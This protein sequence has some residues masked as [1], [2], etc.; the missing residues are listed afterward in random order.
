MMSVVLTS[1]QCFAPV[2]ERFDSG[3]GPAAGPDASVVVT[4][5]GSV[6]AVL[7]G[8]VSSVDASMPDASS[9][10]DAGVQLEVCDGVDNDHDGLIDRLPDGGL[11]EVSCALTAGVCATAHAVCVDGGFTICKYGV[12]YEVVERRCD[13]LDNDCDGRVDKSAVRWYVGRD[14]G[15][16]FNLELFGAEVFLSDAGVVINTANSMVWLNADL[17]ETNRV[18]FPQRGMLLNSRGCSRSQLDGR[19]STRGSYFRKSLRTEC[20]QSG[21]MDRLR[22]IL[23]VSRCHSPRMTPRIEPRRTTSMR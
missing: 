8:S 4:P 18:E 11:L 6:E 21:L 5:D 13:G 22:R 7:D 14:G 16:M 10:F 20:T 12:D 9:S 15:A 2:S 19:G 1:C 17:V 3:V 23:S